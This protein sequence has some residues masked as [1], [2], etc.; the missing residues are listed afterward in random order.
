MV[1]KLVRHA[2]NMTPMP[3]KRAASAALG[4]RWHQSA[5]GGMWDQVGKLQFDFLVD[6]GL[7][8]ESYLL[9]VGCGSLRGGTWF[10][11]Y[12]N[13]AHYYGIDIDKSLLTAGTKELAARNLGGKKPILRSTDTFD[14]DFGTEFEFAIA[15]SVFTH[16]PLNSIQRCLLNVSHVLAPGGRLYATFFRNSN[17]K[18]DVRPSRHMSIT[19]YLDRDPFHYD[20]SAF[21]WLCEGTGL[22]LVDLGDWGHPRGQEM[23]AF[24]RLA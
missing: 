12:L 24:E 21:E 1:N 14:A 10:I 6:H 2:K 16:L 17:G 22:G 8:A 3:V 9:D 20:V 23:L 7:K 15:Q 4:R 18:N 5:V 19:A 13:P 11:E